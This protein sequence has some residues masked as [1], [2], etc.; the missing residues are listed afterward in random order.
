MR[1]QKCTWR[2]NLQE[3]LLS[4]EIDSSS[5]KSALDKWSRFPFLI[6]KVDKNT[7]FLFFF[8]QDFFFFPFSLSLFFFKNLLH[9]FPQTSLFSFFLF[10]SWSPKPS[11]T[12]RNFSPTFFLVPLL[13]LSL[14]RISFFFF[15]SSFFFLF[16]NLSDFPSQHLYH[17]IFLSFLLWKPTSSTLE[18][19]NTFSSPFPNVGNCPS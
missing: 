1:N 14:L 7:S 8:S 17:T 19:P 6:C 4:S 16:K 18:P 3:V 2:T 15:L 12:L 13:Q 11:E 5:T 10:F 9:F